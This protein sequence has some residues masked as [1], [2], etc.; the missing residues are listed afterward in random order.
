MSRPNFFNDN[1]NRTFPF[2]LATTGVATP[3]EGAVTL[4]QLP[5]EF[6]ADCGFIMGPE[7]GFVEGR[8]FVYLYRVELVAATIVF[9]FRADIH[10]TD[11]VGAPDTRVL[12]LEF[13]RQS[14]DP[15]YTS[16]F[17][18]AAVTGECDEPLWLGY[19]VTGPIGKILERLAAA[20][21]IVYAPE[22]PTQARVEPALI[23]NLNGNQVVSLNLANG[24][25]T[26]ANRPSRCDPYIWFPDPQATHINQECLQGDLRLRSGY[27][28]SISQSNL[29]NTIQFSAIVRAGLGEP[30]GEVK[31]FADEAPPLDASNN[32]LAGDF[33]CNEVLRSVNGLQGPTIT[34]FAGTGVAIA[35]DSANSTLIVD[36]N[37]TD[38]SLCTYSTVA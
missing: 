5:D 11:E 19:L 24:D 31:L 35:A 12:S 23:Q 33:Y 6:V 13:T 34:V 36:I 4:L 14:S 26:R 15:V 16:E 22:A 29:S 27:N 1:I 38:L 3:G 32:L 9:E 30:C 21:L 2:Q 7:S 20:P 8:D 18:E 37:L 17:S 25:R 28:V 10:L